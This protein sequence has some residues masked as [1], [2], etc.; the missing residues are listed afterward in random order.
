MA[1]ASLAFHT[2]IAELPVDRT[3]KKEYILLDSSSPPSAFSGD[4]FTTADEK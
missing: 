4:V 3:R 1:C 2:A